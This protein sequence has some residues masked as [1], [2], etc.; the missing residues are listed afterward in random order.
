MQGKTLLPYLSLSVDDIPTLNSADGDRPSKSRRKMAEMID[1]LNVALGLKK[2]R[3][4]AVGSFSR[5]APTSQKRKTAQLIYIIYFYSPC[6][7]TNM[8][9]WRCFVQ[10]FRNKL[11]KN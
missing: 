7:K 2:G 4:L 6:V 1:D 11:K 9:V 5:G 10:M 8:S 3:R